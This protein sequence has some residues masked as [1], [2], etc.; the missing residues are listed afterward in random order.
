MRT[1]VRGK[2][3]DIPTDDRSYVERRMQRLQRI[4]DDRSEAVVELSVEHHRSAQ[5]S[6]IVD[7]SL[8]IDGRPLHG[9]A[10]ASS[11]RAAIDEVIDKLERQAVD[12][13]ERPRLRARPDEARRIL[14]SIADGA[15][16]STTKGR[17]IVKVKR[18]AIEPM[19]EEDAVSRM[20][21]LGHS[22]FVFVDAASEHLC[23]LYRRADGDYGIIEPVVGDDHS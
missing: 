5:V 10:G 12:H 17:R 11:H 20:E 15:V 21:D 18:Y 16:D 3:L 7:V 22:F 4:L 1:I 9:S 8:V 13:R 19:F 23:V 2:N 6:H 14:R